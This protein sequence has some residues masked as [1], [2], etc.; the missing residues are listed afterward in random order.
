M[1]RWSPDGKFIAYTITATNTPGVPFQA[2]LR[3]IPAS[4]GA[5]RTIPV[6][7]SLGQLVAIEGWSADGKKL[8][9]RVI[10]PNGDRDIAESSLDGSEQ[11]ILVRFDDRE[12]RPFN[13]FFS[14]D[15]KTIYFTLGRHEA[16]IW[17]MDLKKK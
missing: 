7:V 3:V 10:A 8:Y 9:F 2:P 17:L 1:A 12:K 11:S 16:D 5:A 13:P 15:G 14:T 6:P 4:G